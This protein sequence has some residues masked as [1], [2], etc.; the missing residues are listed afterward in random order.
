MR[1]NFVLFKNPRKV[2]H[3]QTAANR[4]PLGSQRR[5]NDTPFWFY[6]LGVG[7]LSDIILKEADTSRIITAN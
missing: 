1:S 4:F 7:C 2:K 5:E 3:H 6:E